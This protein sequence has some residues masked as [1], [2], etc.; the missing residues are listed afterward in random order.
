[1]SRYIP[2]LILWN[3]IFHSISKERK[4]LFK[5]TLMEAPNHADIK[6]DL[7]DDDFDGEEVEDMSDDDTNLANNNML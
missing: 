6:M 4:N 3:G 7:Q 5:G 1:V 2:K